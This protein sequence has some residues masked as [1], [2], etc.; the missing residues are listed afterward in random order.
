MLTARPKGDLRVWTMTPITMWSLKVMLISDATGEI[1]YTLDGSA[2]TTD[3]KVYVSP[4]RVGG[5]NMLQ[6]VGI[7]CLRYIS[8]DDAGAKVASETELYVFSRP[9]SIWPSIPGGC[10]VADE[11]I[12]LHSN[13]DC[14]V[15]Y[16]LNGECPIDE[17]GFPKDLAHRYTVPIPMGNIELVAVALHSKSGTYSKLINA[18][19]RIDTTTISLAASHTATKYDDPIAIRLTSTHSDAMIKYTLDGTN[20]LGYTAAIYDGPLILGNYPE[21]I[22]LRAIAITSDELS[23]ELKLN[24]EFK[25]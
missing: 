21:D 7:E 2:P 17:L 10:Y 6:E 22:T 24:Y 3:S 25:G 19:Y 5:E 8:T 20:P 9:K 1:Y 18:S 12:V 4:I 15:Y 23:D 11:E 16:T 14:A 13:D